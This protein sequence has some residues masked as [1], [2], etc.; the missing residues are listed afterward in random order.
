[1]SRAVVERAARFL[2]ARVSRRNVLVRSALVGS[3]LSVAPAAYVL[4]PGT[5]YAFICACGNGNCDCASTCCDGYTQF[6]CTLNGGYN[7]CPSGSVVA[8]WWKADGSAFCNGPRYYLDCNALCGCTAGCG[9]GWNFCEPGCDGVNCGCAL[10]DC[11]NWA[12]SCFQFRY[13]QCNQQIDCIG[14]IVCRVVSCIAPW[15]FDATCTTASAT[16]DFTAWMDVACNTD[17]PAPPPPPCT[18][19]A[20]QCEV[21]GL[22]PSSDGLGYTMAT[23]FGKILAF[24]DAVNTGDAQS[25]R[26]AQPI[27]SLARTP[28]GRGYWLSA[29]DGGIFA[30]GDAGFFGSMGGKPLDRPMVGMAGTP[31]GK[32]YWTV[33]AD[34]GIFAFGDAGFFGSGA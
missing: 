31:T 12:S 23:A 18:S 10:G 9:G 30:F 22:I 2:D 27:V 13:G 17:V 32:G 21:V 11:N 28:D 4:R 7:W 8:G 20:T 33:A 26:L 1:V 6:C 16:D 19:P 3:A 29:A 14:R 15:Q 5:A 34:G 25:I 24:G